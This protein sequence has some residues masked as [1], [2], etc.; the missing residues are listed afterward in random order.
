VTRAAAIGTTLLIVVLVITA[1]LILV[2]GGHN[3]SADQDKARRLGEKW[4][5]EVV[6]HTITTTKCPVD[7]TSGNTP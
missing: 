1:A 2:L 5:D 4:G 3:P 6:C 7:T